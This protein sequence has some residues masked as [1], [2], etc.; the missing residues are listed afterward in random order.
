M[1]HQIRRSGV[2]LP[3]FSLPSPYGIGCFGTDAYR[4]ADFLAEAGQTVWQ[5]LPLTPTSVGDSPYQSVSAFAGNPYLIDPEALCAE[6][7]L[8]REEW[9]LALGR[10]SSSG[11]D[12]A[13][14]YQKRLPLLRLAYERF[15]RGGGRLS[16][17][18]M[19]AN[20]AWLLP[21][22]RFMALKNQNQDRP[23]W[24]WRKSSEPDEEEVG[25]HCFLQQRFSEDWKRL[26][27][28]V[29]GLGIRIVGDLPLYVSADSA[30]VW[31]RPELFCLDDERRPLSVAGCPPDAFSPKGQL[32][33]NPLYRWESHRAEDYSWWMARLAHGFE[34]FDGIRLDHFRGFDAYY[35]IPAH[36]ED[37]TRGQWRQG[38]GHELFRV[39][40]EVLGDR[41]LIAEDLGFMTD[42]A[43]KLVED[44]GFPGMKILQFSFGAPAEGEEAFACPDLPHH[45]PVRSVA[46]PGTHDN[47]TLL[48]W[49]T[50]A[51]EGERR[52]V[53]AY[54]QVP[55]T[56]SAWELVNP[57]LACLS[58]SAAALCVF[59]MTDLLHL[60]D[61][62]RLNTPGHVSGNWQWRLERDALTPALAKQ[63]RT[64]AE[65]GSR[66]IR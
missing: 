42:S 61:G 52:R 43:R 26:R 66:T 2:L 8:R 9:E 5:I 58:R 14:Q 3:I 19:D 57:L 47:Q 18:F 48:G 17:E 16:A 23:F 37:A 38:P 46:Y 44:C 55:E 27:A 21:Y 59:P 13:L 40:E 50:G 22:A 30:D 36:A 35:A 45:Y 6:G 25:F 62:A 39:A 1:S 63:I 7:L 24:E 54:L 15:C 29:N 11:V 12:Y 31:S 32:W 41:W 4:F 33:G 10:C 34:L 64:L 51:T 20:R 49:L 65:L 56:L 60:D 53:A 28:Y